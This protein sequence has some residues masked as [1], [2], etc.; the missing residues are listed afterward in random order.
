MVCMGT[1]NTNRIRALI[2]M[3]VIGASARTTHADSV[4][5]GLIGITSHGASSASSG[6]YRWMPRKISSI[7]Q[8]VWNPELNFTYERGNWLFNAT[9]VSDCMN[10]D[11][12]YLGIGKRWNITDSF[13]A[14]VLAGAYFVKDPIFMNDFKRLEGFKNKV[15]FAPWISLEKDFKISGGVHAFINM[16]SNIA[17]TH[18][19][20]GIKY[21]Y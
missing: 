1:T 16:S 17:L 12:Y 11:A 5:L 15:I 7:M 10:K 13:Y 2:L 14:S 19:V 20:T 6:A 18:A 4:S 21:K 3:I 9:Y 8:T